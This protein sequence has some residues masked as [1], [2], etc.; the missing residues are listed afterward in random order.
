MKTLMV[1]LCSTSL[2]R[3]QAGPPAR[4]SSQAARAIGVIQAIDTRAK[5]ITVKTDAGPEMSVSFEVATRFLRVAPG[6]KDLANA[7]SISSSD[8]EVGDRI[9]ARGRSGDNGQLV[10]ASIIVMSKSDIARKHEAERAEWEKRGIGGLI[11]A[12][13]PGTKEI[14]INRPAVAGSKPVVIALTPGAVLRRYAPNSVKFSDARPCRF[15]DLLVGDQIKALGDFNEDRTRFSVKE[16]VAGSFQNII[17]TVVSLDP[18]KNTILITDL[19][20]GKRVEAQ[21]A[22]DTTIHRL[23]V[24]LAQ[25]VAKR[26]QGSASSSGSPASSQPERP[27]AGIPAKTGGESGRLQSNG[28]LQ[29]AIERLP[30]LSLAD[31]KQGEAIILAC[32]RSAD[33]TRVSAIT[34]LAGVE[35]ILAASSK[36]GRPVDLGSWNLDLNMSAGG[37]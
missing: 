28:D 21:V 2:L 15:E 9:L 37:P 6:A 14:T 20:T 22:V 13:N 33:P 8:L 11:T 25:M 23:S 7:T 29:A 10:A 19:A 18:G 3:F 12:L 26:I 36:G 35:P 16:L 24:D 30:R 5:H 31:L 32:T 4:T 34:L 1:L 27:S 17:G